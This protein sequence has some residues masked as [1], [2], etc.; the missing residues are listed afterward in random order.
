MDL[1]ALI[2]STKGDRSYGDLERASGGKLSGKRWQQIATTKILTFPDPL[3]MP[4]IAQALDVDVR[5]VVDAYCESLGLP[6][7]EESPLIRM[8]PP[9]TADL[10]Q[11]SV[12]D[13]RRIISK[14]V[15]A[16]QAAAAKAAS[17]QEA[18]VPIRRARG[19]R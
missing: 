18:P 5:T 17:E 6:S 14:F 16:D 13:L 3:T 19:N 2:A 10:T 8:M 12:R 15:A 1:Q 9:G 11:E 4:A 7:V